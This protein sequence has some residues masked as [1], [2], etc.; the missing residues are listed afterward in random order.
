MSRQGASCGYQKIRINAYFGGYSV[1]G[2]FIGES[3]GN[4]WDLYRGALGLRMVSDNG[5]SLQIWEDEIKKEH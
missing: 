4:V 3:R 2:R 1:I 5:M